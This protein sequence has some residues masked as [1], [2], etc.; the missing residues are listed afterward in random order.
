VSVK[1]LDAPVPAEGP[2]ESGDG[3]TAASPPAEEYPVDYAGPE[4]EDFA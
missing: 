4:E 3:D 1:R 2:A